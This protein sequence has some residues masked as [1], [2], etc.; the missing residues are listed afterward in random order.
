MKRNV[1]RLSV[2]NCCDDG[3]AL[4]LVMTMGG[5]FASFSLTAGHAHDDTQN[6]TLDTSGGEYGFRTTGVQV[7]PDGTTVDYASIGRYVRDGQGNVVRNGHLEHRGT[8]AHPTI[9]GSYTVNPDCTGSQTSNL[10]T[11]PV[12]HLDFVIVDKGQRV[13]FILNEPTS[14]IGGTQT[15]Q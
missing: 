15:R 1:L 4:L 10:N 12:V 14:T 8:I 13:G 5:L 7:R 6:C 2:G 3:L 9:T 11:G